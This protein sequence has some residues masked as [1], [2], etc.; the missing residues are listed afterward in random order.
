MGCCGV[1]YERALVKFEEILV[2]LLQGAGAMV[3]PEG[4]HYEQ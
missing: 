4:R 3:V 2:Q 1:V